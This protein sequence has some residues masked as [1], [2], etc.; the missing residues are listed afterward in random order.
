MSVLYIRIYVLVFIWS[1]FLFVILL[2]SITFLFLSQ[3]LFL[4][5]CKKRSHYYEQQLLRYRYDFMP[6][7][8]KF[9]IFRSIF[10]CFL[11]DTCIRIDPF[12]RLLTD[13]GLTIEDTTLCIIKGYNLVSRTSSLDIMNLG[14]G[15]CTCSW[16]ELNSICGCL[17]WVLFL[18]L[19]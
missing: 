16:S 10:T 3:F 19:E 11:F 1:C 7:F 14:K 15:I 5:W 13:L 8:G 12:L 18:S 6:R 17:T 4:L 9:F 2:T